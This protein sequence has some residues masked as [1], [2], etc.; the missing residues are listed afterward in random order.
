MIGPDWYRA[1]TAPFNPA[2][3]WFEWDWNK[4]SMIRFLG[5]HPQHPEKIGG[6]LSEIV[7]NRR[8]EYIGIKHIGEIDNGVVV[9]KEPL[10]DAYE[11]YTFTE[12]NWVTT[13]QV[14]IGMNL[15]E[16]FAKYMAD[17]RPK[18]LKV[19]KDLSEK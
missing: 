7:D 3:S 16:E 5:P 19:L 12:E 2:W 15:A 11:N 18:A 8:Y 1:R 14:E 6:M 10:K 9:N 4:G 13:V 17:T